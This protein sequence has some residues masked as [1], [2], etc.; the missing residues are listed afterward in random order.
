[1]AEKN[2]P[3]LHDIKPRENVGRDTISRY[4]AQFR[5]ATNAAL[6]ILEGKGVDRVYCDYHDDFVVRNLR[7]GEV[8]YHFFQVKTKAKRNYQWNL[9]DIFGIYKK[10]TQVKDKIVNSFI[11][12]LLLHTINFENSC[13]SVVFLTNI[14][15]VDEIEEM[16]S[17]LDS[18]DF[19]NKHN[20]ILVEEFNDCY[21]DNGQEFNDNEIKEL[22]SKLVLTPGV[23]YLNEANDFEAVAREKIYKFSEIDLEY[24]EAKEIVDNLVVLA[25][26]K[27]FNKLIGDVSESELDDK[28]GIGI[29]DL[30][31][32]LSISRGAYEILLNGG[33]LKAIKNASV[34]QRKL[35]QAGASIEMIEYCCEKKIQWD[36]W[37][38]NKRHVI[39]EYD[40]KF[41]QEDINLILKNLINGTSLLQDIQ[42]NVDD[43]LGALSGKNIATHVDRELL[44]GGVFSA[45]VRSEAQ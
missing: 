43:L 14:H 13:G 25:E 40:L 15:F 19:S 35:K 21:C 10:K 42:K 16:I 29:N 38:R 1:M 24:I 45:L 32:V 20:K 34:L 7:K 33:D 2:I 3:K 22:L 44:L 12:K 27:S 41:L 36:E 23:Q 5:A 8:E 28:A 9:L 4:Q 26:N 11:G 30:L 6:E 31:D 18:G 39:P 17:D 37:Y